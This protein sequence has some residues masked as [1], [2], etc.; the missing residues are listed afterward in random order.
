VVVR[1]FWRNLPRGV[2]PGIFQ[3][4]V[5]LIPGIKELLADKGGGSPYYLY[6]LKLIF[7]NFFHLPKHLP[8]AL[9]QMA[10]SSNRASW[11]IPA[12]PCQAYRVDH[13]TWRFRFLPRSQIAGS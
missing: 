4:C 6:D 5:S 7:S 8:K 13:G 1:T 12:R 2:I 10:S 3:E 9:V 11:G